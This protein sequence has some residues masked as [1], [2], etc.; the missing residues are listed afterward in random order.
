MDKY[1][2]LNYMPDYYKGVYEMEELLKAQGTAL[3]LFDDEDEETL[4]NQFIMKANAKGIAI[5]EDEAGIKP[6]PGDSLETRRNN[7]LLHLLPPK[8][9][10]V[11][12]LNH[13]FDLMGLQVTAHVE[14][15]QRLAVIDGNS[16]EIG[17]E[18]IQSIKYM[19]NICLPATMNYLI[20][21][22][23]TTGK[24]IDR[25]YVGTA[26]TYDLH[27]TIQAN[28]DQINF[29]NEIINRIYVG[30]GE[31]SLHEGIVE[32]DISQNFKEG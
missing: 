3:A 5:F 17:K 14:H 7:V 21:V 24:T 18:Q 29:K 4:L 26:N 27:G 25:L 6:N 9:L 10:T 22:T 11:R 16:A 1:Y 13:L 15:D 23:I 8:P 2:I 32:A 30:I 12:Y 28:T 31:N 20:R 19:L